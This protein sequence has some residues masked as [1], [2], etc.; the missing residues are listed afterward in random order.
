MS[1]KKFVWFSKTIIIA[2]LF[3]AVTLLEANMNIIQQLFGVSWFHIASIALPLFMFYLRLVTN[4]AV[5]PKRT[6]KQ[7]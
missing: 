6:T 4:Q 7:E 3:E 2:M 1:E 5:T